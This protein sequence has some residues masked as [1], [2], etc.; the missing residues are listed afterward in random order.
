MRNVLIVAAT[1][2]FVTVAGSLSAQNYNPQYTPHEQ[3]ASERLENFRPPPSPP[4]P[5]N[6][7]DALGAY[8]DNHR[9]QLLFNVRSCKEYGEGCHSCVA[10]GIWGA[11]WHNADC[12]TRCD[13]VCGNEPAR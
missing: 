9:Q 3:S 1:I 4:R 12:T 8:F 10:D 13:K 2:G 6:M 7:R 11:L 5:A